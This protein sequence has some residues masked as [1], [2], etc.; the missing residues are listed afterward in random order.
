M[1]VNSA[2]LLCLFA[3]VCF[4]CNKDTEPE[5]PILPAGATA[6]SAEEVAFVPY[7]DG[8]RVFKKSPDFTDELILTFKERLATEE[9]YAWNQTYF[10][11]S[12]DPYLELELRL[13]YLQAE[14]QAEKTLAIYMPYRD[15]NSFPRA[16]IFEMPL[17]TAGIE[18]GFFSEIITF[19]PSIEING[20][21]WDNVYEVSPL[22][23]TDEEFD[24]PTNYSKVFYNT[25]FGIIE[26]DQ[27]NGDKWIL[28]P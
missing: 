1:K 8:E 10:T 9:V 28:H 18:T 16:S 3:L 15:E 13:R 20:I 5:G 17:D 27:K 6:Y 4:S 22:T 19:H 23:S 2:I 12:S 7:N 11:L 26:L 21:A 14:N 25:V 24:H